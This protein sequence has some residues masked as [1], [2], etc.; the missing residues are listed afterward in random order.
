MS[1]SVKRNVVLAVV[2][3]EADPPAQCDLTSSTPEDRRPS[4][5]HLLV[6]LPLLAHP[7]GPGCV[8]PRPPPCNGGVVDRDM[9]DAW[10]CLQG[11]ARRNGSAYRASPAFYSPVHELQQGLACS[12]WISGLV[13]DEG[14]QHA[15]LEQ[16]QGELLVPPVGLA[17]YL[18]V[19]QRL[20][21]SDR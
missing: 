10:G 7:A 1:R 12:L 19:T 3:S 20:V 9:V 15:D 14:V 21:H 17:G 5:L 16:V 2:P 18:V 8:L 13:E 6:V 11:N 4:P